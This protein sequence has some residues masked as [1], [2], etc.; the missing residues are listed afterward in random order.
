[1][2][3]KILKNIIL[4]DN[5]NKENLTNHHSRNRSIKVRM[6]RMQQDDEGDDFGEGGQ[7][8]GVLTEQKAKTQKP[9]LYKVLLHNDDFTP[10]D[11]VVGIL[12]K[13]FHKDHTQ[14]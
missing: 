3:T 5:F 14:A 8:S 2:A 12:E 6:I 11:F 1:M 4:K 9:S 10:M 13:V 7:Q